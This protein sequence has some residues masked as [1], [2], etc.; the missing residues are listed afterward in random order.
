[1][2]KIILSVLFFANTALADAVIF[3]GNDVKTLKQNI[4]LFG[5]AKIL[6]GSLNPSSGAGV[7]APQGSIY[8]STTV[9]LYEKTG[10][11]NTAWTKYALLPVNLATQ[12]T[13]TLPVTN[14]GTGTATAFTQG[15]IPFAGASGVYTQNNANFFWDN[16]NSFLGLGTATPT[17]ALSISSKNY[18]S[19]A[20]TMTANSGDFTFTT[21]APV[22]LNAGD[23]LMPTSTT[24]QERTVTATATGTSFSVSPAFSGNVAGETYTVY[25]AALNINN[26]RIFVS[27]SKGVL[28]LGNYGVG[29]SHKFSVIQDLNAGEDTTMS[30]T[31]YASP[32][33][34]NFRRLNGTQAA[35]TANVTGNV[36]QSYVSQTTDDGLT[37]RTTNRFQTILENTP[38]VGDHQTAYL[39]QV[40]P[41]GSSAAVERMRLNSKGYLG[42][43]STATPTARLFVSGATSDTTWTTAGRMMNMN[44]ATHTDTTGTGTIATKVASSFGIPTFASSSAT[45]VTTAS[46]VYIAGPPTAGTNTT[47]TKALALQVAAGD[48]SFAGSIGIATTT[49]STILSFGGEA[50][51]TIGTERRTAAD[52]AGLGLTVQT[53]G[54]TVGATNRAGGNLVLSSGTST[55]TGTSSIT[56]NTATAGSSGTADNAPTTKMTLIGS[57]SLGLGLAAPT[58]LLHI[59]AGTGNNTIQKFTSGTTTGQLVGD[60]LDVGYLAAGGGYIWNNENTI[61]QFGT[62]NTNRMQI[63]AAGLVSIG[64]TAPAASAK[65]DIQGTDG[66]LLFPRMTT[67]QKNALTPTAGMQVYDTTLGRFECYIAAWQQCG[68]NNP[69]TTTGD[70]IYGG[71]SGTPT[72]LAGGTTGQILVTQGT[73]GAPIWQNLRDQ[74]G[75]VTV[76]TSGSATFRMEAW[77]STTADCTASPCTALNTTDGISSVGRSTTGTYTVNFSPAFASQPF[78]V[79]SN[80]RGASGQ[81]CT[82]NNASLTSSAAQV[83]CQTSNSGGTLVDS[84]FNIICIGFR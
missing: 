5:V 54:A 26:G 25:P 77:N 75:S 20:V 1:M 19:G 81:I 71:A 59:D 49:P 83:T 11:G 22:T 30:S 8:M 57:G 35:P 39:W 42:V 66:A 62:N 51:R 61:M 12:V 47:I 14:G 72:R 55:G 41:P 32:V 17:S 3:S 37:F 29:P 60:G 31:A 69:M 7:A 76:T 43:G 38:V 6:S 4:D 46:N 45:T 50:A 74:V 48:S 33:S 64:T 78:C 27:G 67:T 24:G 80:A 9:G 58:A 21:S 15:S 10:A 36:I 28:G 16:T 18:S 23:T 13:G 44:A 73:S 40:S 70:L 2:I 63:S 65:L 34:F 84:R 68:L 52:T 82:V 56:F 53:G 79:T